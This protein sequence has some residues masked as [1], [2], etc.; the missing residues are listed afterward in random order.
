M[1]L[2]RD[3]EAAT[4]QSRTATYPRSSLGTATSNYLLPFLG[5]EEGHAT[6]FTK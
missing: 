4:L 6:V 2:L 1:P 3:K 5:R